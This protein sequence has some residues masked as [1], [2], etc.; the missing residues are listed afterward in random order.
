M[1]APF[2]KARPA[3]LRRSKTTF[4]NHSYRKF[5]TFSEINISRQA[6]PFKQDRR[7]C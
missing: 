6:S 1:T 5:I 3:F 7:C 2:P 4:Q